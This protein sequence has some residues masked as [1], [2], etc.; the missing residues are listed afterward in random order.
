MAWYVYFIQS[1]HGGDIKIGKARD[2]EKRR[3]DLQTGR[4]DNLEIRFTLKCKTE[5]EAYRLEHELHQRFQRCL[6]NREWFFPCQELLVY[7]AE[8]RVATPESVNRGI[9]SLAD[10][11][12]NTLSY[13]LGR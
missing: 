10:N 13:F 8:N 11:L 6:H 12:I 7:L 1:E 2:V 3:Q 4:P 9:I 5:K